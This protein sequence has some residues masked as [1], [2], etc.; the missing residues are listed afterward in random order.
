MDA[1]ATWM[2]Y[3]EAAERVKVTPA[4]VTD[5]ACRL[6]WPSRL[7]NDNTPEV[8]VP[9]E[10]LAEAETAARDTTPRTVLAIDAA[11]LEAAV[12]A[13]VQPLQKVIDVLVENSRASRAAIETLL[14]ERNAARADVAGLRE[15]ATVDEQQIAD[16]KPAL[17]REARDRRSLQTQA[18]LAREAHHAANERAARASASSFR[19]ELRRED[20]EAGIAQLRHEI[21]ALKSRKRRW[22]WP[23]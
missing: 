23:G 6:K 19:E 12:K 7:R 14:L 18:D 3:C 5:A 22:W 20:L 4:M 9:G 10:V 11:T 13:A 8:E 15:K 2:T 17:E 16:L 21:E 1:A